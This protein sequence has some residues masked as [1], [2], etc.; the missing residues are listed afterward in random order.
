MLVAARTPVYA[1]LTP[2]LPR[3][4][5]KSNSCKNLTSFNSKQYLSLNT[6]RNKN[7]ASKSSKKTVDKKVIAILL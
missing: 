1:A 2:V 5:F 7:H 6:G 3:H 4:S